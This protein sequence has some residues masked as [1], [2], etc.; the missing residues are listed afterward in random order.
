M[1]VP[2]HDQRDWEFA[3]KYG[4]AI[5]KVI[6]KETGIKRHNELYANG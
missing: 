4:I 6:A 2:A 5:K 3:Y 1:F